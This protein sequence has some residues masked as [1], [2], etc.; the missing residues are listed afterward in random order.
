[1]KKL[2]TFLI[3]LTAL[4]SMNAQEENVYILGN[5]GDQQWDPSVGTLM[6]YNDGMY[7]YE[8]HFNA[9]S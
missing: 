5:V 9:A 4:V 3:M 2:F 1:M 6:E 7:E 8:G